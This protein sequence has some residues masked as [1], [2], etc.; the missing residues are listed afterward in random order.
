MKLNDFDSGYQHVQRA[1]TFQI[2]QTELLKVSL[3]LDAVALVK[4]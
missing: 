2:Y 1:L 4:F 3:L